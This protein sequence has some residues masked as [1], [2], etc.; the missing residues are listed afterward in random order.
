MDAIDFSLVGCDYHHY[1]FANHHPRLS[2]SSEQ[3]DTDLLSLAVDRL[4][5]NAVSSYQSKSWRP[6]SFKASRNKGQLFDHDNAKRL[7]ADDDAS[8]SQYPHLQYIAP[9]WLMGFTRM[10]HGGRCCHWRWIESST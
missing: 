2:F 5:S 6:I 10:I 3:T 1:V 7:C 4:E 9:L 8:P